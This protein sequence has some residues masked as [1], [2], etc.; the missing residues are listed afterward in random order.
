M[1]KRGNA[2][3]IPFLVLWKNLPLTETTWEYADELCLRFPEF[4]L[5]DKV[6]VCIV[7]AGNKKRRKQNIEGSGIDMFGSVVAVAFQIT[8]HAE[9]HVNDVFLF[10]KIIFDIN[11]SKRSKTYKSY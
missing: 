9:M 8:F 2:A 1:V 5:E 7:I 3:V 11:T 6:M 10:F 4:H